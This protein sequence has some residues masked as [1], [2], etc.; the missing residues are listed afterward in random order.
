MIS[1]RITGD[2]NRPGVAR[3]RSHDGRL[4]IG[5]MNSLGVTAPEGVGLFCREHLKR[6]KN[7]AGFAAIKPS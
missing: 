5:W 7:S 4:I 6:A 2:M 1:N 3:P